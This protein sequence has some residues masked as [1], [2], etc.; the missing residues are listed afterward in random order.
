M[1]SKLCLKAK[2]SFYRCIV[3]FNWNCWKKKR[4]AKW[5][6]VHRCNVV[7]YENRKEAAIFKITREKSRFKTKSDSSF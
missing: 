6:T 4:S 7:K 5:S 2:F 1:I 3:P